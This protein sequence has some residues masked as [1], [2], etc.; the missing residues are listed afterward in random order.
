MDD[1]ALPQG[2]LGEQPILDNFTR[3]ALTTGDNTVLTSRRSNALWV[4]LNRPGSK[5]AL[6]GSMVAGLERAVEEA[7]ADDVHALVIRGAGGTFCSGADLKH[8]A[9]L[10][11]H[12]ETGTVEFIA[13][14]A[15]V[16]SSFQSHPFVTVA[17]VEG[18]ALAGGFEFLLAADL[19][20]ARADAQIGDRH[21]EYGLLPGA[22][23]SVRLPRAVSGARAR[24]LMLTGEMLD[25]RTAAEWGLAS[26]A[27]SEE[28]F[29]A[30]LETIVARVCSRSGDA[31]AAAKRMLHEERDL[32]LDDAIACE[33]ALVADY[34]R[35][36]PDGRAGLEAFASKT[37]PEFGA[38]T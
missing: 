21:L 31:L 35:S 3:A 10:R 12:T 16:F 32:G 19:V 30:G 24:Y 15:A 18:Y 38:A 11:D 4:T 23:G 6:N 36:S 13:R 5:N 2:R 37:K 8:M 20:I 22:G 29:E 17:A 34:R 26:H 14:L 27:F 1:V 28:E 25:G 7:L 9:Y 33:R